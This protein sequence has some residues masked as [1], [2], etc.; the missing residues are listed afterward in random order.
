MK[1]QYLGFVPITIVIIT[2]LIV[3]NRYFTKNEKEFFLA[4]FIS[5]VIIVISYIGF[6]W[7]L[8]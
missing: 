5:I 8:S 6:F 3:L 4:V 7:G 2:I 1:T